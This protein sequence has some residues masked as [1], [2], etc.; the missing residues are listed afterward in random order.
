M[1]IAKTQHVLNMCFT[2]LFI[3]LKTV[4][5]YL[6]NVFWKNCINMLWCLMS[7]VNVSLLSLCSALILQLSVECNVDKFDDECINTIARSIV[8]H[9][10]ECHSSVAEYNKIQNTKHSLVGYVVNGMLATKAGI[11]NTANQ[12]QSYNIEEIIL[13]NGKRVYL[14]KNS[15]SIDFVR[16]CV[17]YSQFINNAISNNIDSNEFRRSCNNL[18]NALHASAIE[19]LNQS[20]CEAREAIVNEFDKPYKSEHIEY[21]NVE[22]KLRC[23]Q[24]KYIIFV[25]NTQNTS[26]IEKISRFAFGTEEAEVRQTIATTRQEEMSNLMGLFKFTRN[27]I[28]EKETREAILIEERDEIKRIFAKFKFNVKEIEARKAISSEEK[29]TRSIMSKTLDLIIEKAKAAQAI[30]TEEQKEQAS[31]FN[32]YENNLLVLKLNAVLAEE[33]IARMGIHVELER[34]IVSNQE[35]KARER[36]FNEFKLI[37]K[38]IEARKA[39]LI[40]EENKRV[41][42]G[43]KFAAEQDEMLAVHKAEELKILAAERNREDE[44]RKHNKEKQRLFVKNEIEKR[45]T[46]GKIEEITKYKLLEEL[47]KKILETEESDAKNKLKIKAMEREIA[48]HDSEIITFYEGNESVLDE[49]VNNLTKAQD[50][51]QLYLNM[52]RGF[53]NEERKSELIESINIKKLTTELYKKNELVTNWL[54]DEENTLKSKKDSLSDKEFLSELVEIINSKNLHLAEFNMF[55]EAISEYVKKMKKQEEI[56]KKAESE[57]K[58]VLEDN[59]LQMVTKEAMERENLQSEINQQYNIEMEAI[60]EKFHTNKDHIEYINSNYQ[61]ND[62]DKLVSAQ[63]HI[64]ELISPIEVSGLQMKGYDSLS[65]KSEIINDRITLIQK[66]N[67]K[68]EARRKVINEEKELRKEIKK[69]ICE[70]FNQLQENQTIQLKELKE[71]MRIKD[72]IPEVWDVAYNEGNSIDAISGALVRLDEAHKKDLLNAETRDELRV[73]L[74]MQLEQHD[75]KADHENNRCVEDKVKE[76]DSSNFRKRDLTKKVY[77]RK[78]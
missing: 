34:Q 50:K 16:Q 9:N 67:S 39:I 77:R 76:D 78:Y 21:A 69:E 15:Q 60:K 17:S 68:K 71:R 61:S 4:Q 40:E 32:D 65:Q 66:R 14:L 47:D 48:L 55:A 5:H 12:S 22:E 6:R 63:V 54:K 28:A 72:L 41:S 56:R 37:V 26:D 18:K 44:I 13:P 53:V 20:E 10:D 27:D 42:D 52:N 75:I 30:L 3:L 2:M 58:T 59:I 8:K 70:G 25:E 43:V 19:K 64:N 57:Q 23:S 73:L 74:K 46:L 31:I 11:Y 24:L 36:M 1:K 62:L 7:K 49:L 51:L 38:K 45:V 33:H 35:Q 29:K